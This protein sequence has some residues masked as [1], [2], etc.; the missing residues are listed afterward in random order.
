[1][2]LWEMDYIKVRRIIKAIHT[3]GVP[4]KKPL[5]GDLV[6][7]TTDPVDVSWN[8]KD[9]QLYALGVGAKVAD[10]LNYL[11][12]GQGPDVI[13]SFGAIAGNTPLSKVYK[14]VDIDHT[15]LLHGEQ[16][17]TLHRPLSPNT[18]AKAI[19]KVVN[20]WDKRKAAILE[21]EGE[22]ADDDGVI[23]TTK[24][25][26]FIRGAGGFGGERGPS[27]AKDISP[28]RPPDFE[29]SEQVTLEQAAL[30]RLTGDLNPLHIEPEFAKQAGFDRPILHGMSTYGMGCR[31]AIQSLLEGNLARLK[32]YRGRMTGV[33]YPGDVLTIK[34]WKRTSN[35]A[36]VAIQARGDQSVLN[37]HITHE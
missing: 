27:S 16:A 2:I 3:K 29:A 19:G 18:K 33:V 37:A 5:N 7:L 6:G 26:L 34:I 28:D 17:I 9:A 22:V 36:F 11:Y 35:E 21:V 32:S 30:Y 25:S 4:V 31:V 12:E 14:L 1:M 24:A 20:V 8:F 23:F 13:P 15:K 10:D